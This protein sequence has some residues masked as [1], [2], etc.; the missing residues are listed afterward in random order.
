MKKKTIFGV[1]S[2]LVILGVGSLAVILKHKSDNDTFGLDSDTDFDD[3]DYF[4]G[5][6][7]YAEFDDSGVESEFGIEKTKDELIESLR[8]M[9]DEELLNLGILDKDSIDLTSMPI[10][11]LS[12]LHSA[13][14]ECEA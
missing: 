4:D 8:G 9:S 14:S 13:S 10:N 6:D 11:V 5:I 2:G 1:V 3:Y 12:S 7:E